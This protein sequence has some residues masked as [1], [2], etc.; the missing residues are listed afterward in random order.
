MAASDLPLG[1]SL[2]SRIENRPGATWVALS[3]QLNEAADLKPL[4]QLPGPLV[5]DLSGLDRINSV[6]VRDWMDFVRAR[7]QAGIEL[8]FERC[9]PSMVSQMSMITHFMGTRSRV[10]SIQIP[11]LC[12]ACKTEHLHVLEV[13]RGVQIQP[14]IPCPNCRAAMEVDDLLETYIEAL[15]T[16]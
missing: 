9:S 10:K 4:S 6:G 14:Q 12:T 2:R 13:T 8:T 16:V 15:R 11:Y 1:P 7:E 3:G 5:I